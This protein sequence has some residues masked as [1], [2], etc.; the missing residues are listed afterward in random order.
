MS[1]LRRRCSNGWKVAGILSMPLPRGRQSCVKQHTCE[2]FDLFLLDWHVPDLSGKKY[3]DGCGRSSSQ[4]CLFCLRPT[5]IRRK[6]L[7]RR[8]LPV[9]MIT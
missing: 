6:T 5:A 3:C 4:P 7:W 2:S 1:P 8:S 9:P